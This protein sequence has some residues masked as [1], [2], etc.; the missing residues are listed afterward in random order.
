MWADLLRLNNQSQPC[1]WFILKLLYVKF[2]WMLFKKKHPCNSGWQTKRFY[3]I[4]VINLSVLKTVCFSVCVGLREGYW[5]YSWPDTLVIALDSLQGSV[6]SRTL[7]QVGCW[8]V[9]LLQCSL[10]RKVN[11]LSCLL[12]PCAGAC[13]L[14]RWSLSDRLKIHNSNHPSPVIIK[15]AAFF[16]PAVLLRFG[17]SRLSLSSRLNWKLE[18]TSSL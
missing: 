9:L 13:C 18:E 11:V 16:F 8:G 10:T 17:K 2:C 5:G 12:P 4:M 6:L 15:G 14:Q 7:W 1:I 3:Q